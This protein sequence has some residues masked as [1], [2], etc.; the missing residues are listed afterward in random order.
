MSA[1]IDPALQA[2]LARR[3]GGQAGFQAW[4]ARQGGA[5]VPAPKPA[6]IAPAVGS[7]WS[8]EHGPVR[9]MGIVEGYVVARRKG[10]MP[11]LRGL[12]D[13]TA[14]FKPVES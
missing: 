3:F 12:R 4:L 6:V 5:P 11:F 1:P 9:V 7:R 10:A 2:R 13:F 14:A 8:D